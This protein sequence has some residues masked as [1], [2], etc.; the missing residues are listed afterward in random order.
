MS[1]R[2]RLDNSNISYDLETLRK[3]LTNIEEITLEEY[4]FNKGL[5]GKIG[6][7]ELWYG[8]LPSGRYVY[9]FKWTSYSLRQII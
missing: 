5:T 6:N 8:K 1:I 7:Q 2:M 3:C 9:L 4:S